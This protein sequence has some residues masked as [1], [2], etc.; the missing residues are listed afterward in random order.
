MPAAHTTENTAPDLSSYDIL[1]VSSSAGKDSQAM[2][3]YMV[4]LAD[5]QGVRNRIVVVHADLGRV[6]WEGTK[7]LAAEQ[8]AHYGVRFEVVRRKQDLLG[9]IAQRGMWPSSKQRFCT[10]DHKRDQITPLMTRLVSESGIQG[11]VVRIL[12]CQGI[13]AQESAERAKKTPFQVNRRAS[14]GKRHVDTWMPIFAW[15]LDDVWARIRQSGVRHH[16]AYDLGMKRLSCVF[17]VFAP[18]HALVTAGKHNLGLLRQ[19]AQVETAI[20]HTFRRD[21]KLVDIL[22]LVENGQAIAA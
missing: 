11:R 21:T 6:E 10:S 22:A 2:L 12:D 15:S 8:A 20:G 14:N 13:R 5:A 19:Y 4:E 18:Q 1:L 16:Y 7:E 9:Q 3:D 17:C